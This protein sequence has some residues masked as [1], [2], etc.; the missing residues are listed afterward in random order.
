MRRCDGQKIIVYHFEGHELR[1]QSRFVPRRSRTLEDCFAFCT[2]FESHYS[3]I[4]SANSCNRA[5]HA[6]ATWTSALVEVMVGRQS[7]GS[8]RTT[9]IGPAGAC[10]QPE[11]TPSINDTLRRTGKRAKHSTHP[12]YSFFVADRKKRESL[13]IFKVAGRFALSTSL[14][15]ESAGVGRPCSLVLAPNR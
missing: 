5:M 8:R 15:N 6:A 10:L 12:V 1:Q 7:F 14:A 9:F 2:C 4:G 3:A 11:G 13:G